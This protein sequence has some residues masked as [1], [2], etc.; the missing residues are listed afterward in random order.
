MIVPLS[1]TLRPGLRVIR[2]A[3]VGL[4]CALALPLPESP[5]SAAPPRFTVTRQTLTELAP[6]FGTVEGVRTLPARARIS[7]TVARIDVK[8]GDHVTAGQTLATI[9]DSTLLT[10]Q[11][12]LDAQVKGARAQLAEAQLDFSR[13]QRLV[14]QGAVSRASFDQARSVLRVAE[15]TLAATLAQRDTI[16]KQIDQGAVRAPH[17]GLV[18]HTPIAA[19]SVLMPG[20]VVAEL[21]Q[22]PFRVRL[23]VPERDTRF[24]HVGALIRVDGAELG[25]AP[26]LFG[27][28]DEIKPGISDGRLIAYATVPNLP[29]RFVGIRVEAWLPAQEHQAIVIPVSFILTLSGSDYA[30]VRQNDGTVIEVPI[31]RGAARPTP[32]MPDGIEVLSGLSTGEVLVPPPATP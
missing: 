20:D 4:G 10:R 32:T 30:R 21:A 24:V 22:A 27:T 3:I 28:I 14:G 23:A 2:A 18:L 1:P 13:T 8:D 16:T 17:A 29:D 7:G 9:A 25:A 5:A 12:T 26:T 11:T 31:Q 6:V 19:G 15:S